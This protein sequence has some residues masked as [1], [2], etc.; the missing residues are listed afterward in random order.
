[1]RQFHRAKV[2][3]VSWLVGL[4]GAGVAVAT[5]IPG[6]GDNRSDCYVEFDV[7]GATGT[8]NHVTCTD[9]DPACDTD[10]QCQNICTFS[11]RLCVNQTNISGCTPKPFKRPPSVTSRVLRVPS[12][13]GAEAVC[14]DPANVTLGVRRRKHIVVRASESGPPTHGDK[15]ILFL[16]CKRRTG[17]CPTTTTTTSSTTTTLH[18]P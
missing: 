1:M 13:R 17:A 18:A 6:G 8:S 12:T 14:G 3:G 9:G 5:L 15:D 10:G 16:I 11:V 4:L 7:Q 2:A